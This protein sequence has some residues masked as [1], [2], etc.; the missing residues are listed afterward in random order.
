MKIYMKE[1]WEDEI[2]RLSLMEIAKR[3]LF[4]LELPWRNNE[5]FNSC[6]PR[7]MT[8]P[9]VKIYSPKFKCFVWLIK[10]VSGRTDIEIHPGNF[11]Y[12]TTGCPLPGF[13]VVDINNDRKYDVFHSGD[14]MKFMFANLPDEWE[15]A[16]E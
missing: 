3:K 11:F 7:H 16:I 13:G 12:Q 14:A 15:L 2:Q 6:I 1:I 4:I 9:V 5:L 10:D 8:Y